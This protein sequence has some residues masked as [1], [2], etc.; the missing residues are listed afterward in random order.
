M[1]YVICILLGLVY[2]TAVEAVGTERQN[3]TSNLMV[4]I[5]ILSPK[6]ERGFIFLIKSDFLEFHWPSKGWPSRMQDS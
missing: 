4:Y 5:T 1:K 3:K 2:L 6:M